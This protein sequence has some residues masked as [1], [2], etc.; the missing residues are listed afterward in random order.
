[1]LA[2]IIVSFILCVCVIS[3]MYGVFEGIREKDD[4]LTL[5]CSI[6]AS[7]VGFLCGVCLGSVLF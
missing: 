6:G 4:K 5:L 7:L 2:K 3:L 1:M